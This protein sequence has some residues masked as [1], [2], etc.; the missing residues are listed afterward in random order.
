[1]KIAI[2]TSVHIPWDARI[3][4][5]QAH[6]AVKAGHSVCLIAQ[7]DIGEQIVAG[8]RV[9]GLPRT[10][11]RWH[12]PL[13]WLRLF[14]LALRERADVYHFHDPE[15]LPLGVLLRWVTGRAVIYDA[16]E[17]Y[18]AK[19][20]VRPWIPRRL[21][22][23]VR[24][25]VAS[26]EPMLARALSATITADHLT[27]AGLGQ[28]GVH[29]V[30]TLYNYPRLDV[31]A[32][33]DPDHLSDLPTAPTLLFIGTLGPDRGIWT[34]LD[35]MACLREEYGLAARLIVVGGAKLSGLQERIEAR[36]SELD[37][38]ETVSLEGYVPHDAL[39]AY[40]RRAHLGFMAHDPAIYERNIPT[41]LFEYM[42]A[43]L[44]IITMRADMT[45]FFL[46]Q[47]P[48]GI[49]VDS[50]RPGEYAQAI[51]DLWSH[52]RRLRE[53]ARAGRQAFETRYHWESEGEKLLALYRRLS[54]RQR[55]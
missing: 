45:A 26:I 16:H 5:K 32:P 22:P 7:N 21:R 38:G 11:S 55:G 23:F 44:P 24:D 8:V 4:Y 41:K 33:P 37:I 40:L 48:A 54:P 42:A 25:L 53:M 1:M 47:T 10:R 27:A 28:R 20:M 9:I 12:R 13:N 43:G 36:I 34:M 30:V 19:V 2:L 46:D 51:V 35:T 31:C 18:A 15:L 50:Q 6:T 49:M 14:R 39:S 29:P 52:P 17:H 3:F